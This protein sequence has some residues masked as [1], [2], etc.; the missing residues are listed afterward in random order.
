MIHLYFTS[1][2]VCACACTVKTAH[3]NSRYAAIKVSLGNTL[4]KNNHT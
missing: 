2:K 4:L 1:T 3:I